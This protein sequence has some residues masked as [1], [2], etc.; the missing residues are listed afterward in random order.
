MTDNHT[1]EK[2]K[3]VLIITYYWPPGGGGGVQRWLKFAKYLPEFGITPVVATP[4]N[5]EY[6]VYDYSLINDIPDEVEVVKIP[7]WEPYKLF[8]RFTGRKKDEKVNTGLLSQGKKKSFAEKL[9]IWIRGNLLIPDPRIFWVR[10]ARKR[11]NE[12]LLESGIDTIITTGPPHSVHLI[13]LGLKRKLGVKWIADFRDPWSEIDYLEEFYPSRL[14]MRIQKRLERKVLQKSDKIITVSHN[15]ADDLIRLGAK[16]VQVITNGFDHKDFSH[17]NHNLK[18]EKF[19][20][21]YSGIIHD[22]RNP[23]YLWDTIEELCKT[24]ET[25]S[26]KF[27]L[28][29]FGTIDDKVIGYIESLPLLSKRFH[30]G[31]YISHDLLIKEYEKA[32]CLLLLQNDTKNALGHIPG[33]VF[34][35]LVTKRPILALGPEGNSDIKMIL[36][37]TSSGIACSFKNKSCIKTNLESLFLAFNSTEKSETSSEEINKY[38]RIELTRKLNELV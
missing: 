21:L 2:G 13:G 24:D 15:W 34:E 10:T 16:N 4:E 5:P 37:N 3:K 22:Y 19:T 8:K 11:L 17:F 12:Y 9:S 28:N 33:K 26:D 6:P 31:G 38:S 20:L 23:E 25:F 29:L 18:P 27:Q 35:Y 30:Y 7:I 32:S 36:Q 1:K 14:A